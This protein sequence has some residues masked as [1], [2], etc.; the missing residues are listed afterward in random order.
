M[1]KAT[2][3]SWLL[4][5]VLLIFLAAQA[6]AS[7]HLHLDDGHPA[8]HCDLCSTSANL[9][10]AASHEV[11]FPLVF[12]TA[13]FIVA[14]PSQAFSNPPYFSFQQRAPPINLL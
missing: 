11:L 10:A 4:L 6:Q 13:E 9:N 8:H 3:K 12:A 1:V 7:V 2:Q 14:V 5:S